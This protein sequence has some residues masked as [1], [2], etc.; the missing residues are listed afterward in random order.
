MHIVTILM[1]NSSSMHKDMYIPY[2]TLGIH[3]HIS[4]VEGSPVVIEN[5]EV[6]TREMGKQR[7]PLV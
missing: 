7:F 1:H 2:L 3:S 4:E 5:T 6:Y